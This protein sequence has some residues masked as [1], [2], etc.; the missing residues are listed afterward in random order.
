M[1]V[2]EK[3]FQEKTGYV[4]S[5]FYN[6]NFQKLAF[7]LNSYVR[8]E[9]IAEN[10]ANDT[11]IRAL[12]QIH[13]YDRTKSDFVTWVFTVG[14]NIARAYLKKEGRLSTV[15]MD[16]D[17]DGFTLSEILTT[18]KSNTH[19]QVIIQKKYDYVKECI[20]SLPEKYQ[21]V[22]VMR[23]LENMTYQ[24]IEEYTGLAEGT[25]K[26]QIRKGRQMLQKMCKRN[27]T[28]I[29]EGELL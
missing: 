7:H 9:V 1:K 11:F 19:E 6:A 8:D 21:S 26:S 29:E 27:L 25:V 20:Y 2:N 24:E 28:L 23:E 22:I 4:L 12:D 3:Q 16:K 17:F 18:E 15:S 14:K 5:E 10:L 13:K